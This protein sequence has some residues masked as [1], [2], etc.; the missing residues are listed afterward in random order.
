MTDFRPASFEW[1]KVALGDKTTMAMVPYHRYLQICE[2]QFIEGESY[3]LDVTQ[4]ASSVSRKHFF[5]TVSEAWKNLPEKIA[6]RWPTS[7]HLRRWCLIKSGYCDIAT[8]PLQT[9]QEAR[10]V[11]ALARR[12]DSFAVITIQSCVVTVA[13]AHSQSARGMGRELFQRSKEDCFRV[14][15]ELIG[16]DVATLTSQH[17][18]DRQEPPQIEAPVR[19][20][21]PPHTQEASQPRRAPEPPGEPDPPRNPFSWEAGDRC[22][23]CGS[24]GE[25]ASGC[26]SRL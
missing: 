24:T 25:C 12:L 21:E 3:F 16:T 7:E 11:A 20:I 15:A 10:Q 8:I 23:D 9:K 13:T 4:E 6:G 19:Q 2:R 22:P 26:P 17:P 1:C 18:P 14:L 5:A